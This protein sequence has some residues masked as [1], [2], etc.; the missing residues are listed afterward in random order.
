MNINAVVAGLVLA[1]TL[2]SGTVAQAGSL[3]HGRRPFENVKSYNHSRDAGFSHYK[4]HDRDYRHQRHERMGRVL[5][6]RPIWREDRSCRVSD[7]RLNRDEARVIGALAG[8]AVG[9]L[10][11]REHD[12]ALVGTVAGV[13]IGSAGA[14]IIARHDTDRRR[15][16]E[17]VPKH[18]LKYDQQP[19]AY[20][21]RYTYRGQVY[22][23]R[24]RSHPGR[25]IEIDKYYDRRG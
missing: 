4:R 9:N 6:V 15:G 23:T 20:S 22:T 16:K 10:I 25:Y 19:V 14:D 7:N 8:G 17:C 11:G 1:T 2:L 13:L 21:V 18:K 12:N 24:T 5:D 3:E